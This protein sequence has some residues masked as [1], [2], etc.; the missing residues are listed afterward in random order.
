VATGEGWNDLMNVLAMS[1]SEFNDCVENPSYADYVAAGKNTVG[2]GKGYLAP[3]YFMS[4]LIFITLIFLNLFVAIILNGYFE[5]R[6]EDSHMLNQDVLET[7]RETWSKF[8]PDATGLIKIQYFSDLMFHLGSPFGWDESFKDNT[9]KQERS[10]L[11]A[12]SKIPNYNENSELSF[13]DVLDNI[14][15]IYIIQ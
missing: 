15:L 13:N 11:M 3:M 2:C 6:N 9:E 4:Y 1:K 5:T 10:F 7:F 14:T 12:T 8:D